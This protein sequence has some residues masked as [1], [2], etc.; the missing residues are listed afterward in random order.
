MGPIASE[1][2]FTIWPTSTGQGSTEAPVG[3]YAA[4]DAILRYPDFFKVAVG[5]SGNHD[6]LNYEDDWGK[7]WQGLL[8]EYPD[9]TTNYDNQAN[10]AAGRTSH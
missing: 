6:N 5:E 4:A 1:W 9:G 2:T 10:Q 8:E 3:G 7:K